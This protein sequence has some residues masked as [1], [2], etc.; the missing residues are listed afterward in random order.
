MV[1][2]TFVKSLWLEGRHFDISPK[3]SLRECVGLGRVSPGGLHSLK[4]PTYHMQRELSV[5]VWERVIFI[6]Y[7]SYVNYS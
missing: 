2:S 5:D 6:A 7:T 1:V 4:A 3:V